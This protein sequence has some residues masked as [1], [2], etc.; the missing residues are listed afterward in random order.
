MYQTILE[1]ISN[2]YLKHFL[3][4]TMN[5][6]YSTKS[7]YRV[8]YRHKLYNHF[9]ILLSVSVDQIAHKKY[10]I[11]DG[12]RECWRRVQINVPEFSWCRTLIL[13]NYDNSVIC[14]IW[15]IGPDCYPPPYWLASLAS[16]VGNFINGLLFRQQMNIFSTLL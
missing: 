1:F 4:S 16:N 10:D 13:N 11:H 12:L 14:L 5:I 7:L 15:Q 9:T 6:D 2:C 3:I 8:Y